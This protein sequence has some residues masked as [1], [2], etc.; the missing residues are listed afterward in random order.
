VYVF[1]GGPWPAKADIV[2][3]T[4]G[5]EKRILWHKAHLTVQA[6]HRHI[7]QVIA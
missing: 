5:K 6:V 7:A 1:L 2:E 3:D 4:P